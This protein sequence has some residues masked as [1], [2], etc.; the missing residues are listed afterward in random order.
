VALV[1]VNALSRTLASG[2]QEHGGS[3]LI[4]SHN[5][6]AAH[7]L[8][9]QLGCRFILFEALYTT[10]HDVLIVCDHERHLMPGSAASG[11]HPGYLKPGMTVIDLTA[12]L[13][14]TPL[15][16]E[17]QSRNCAIIEPRRLLLHQLALQGRLLTGKEVTRE[18]IEQAMPGLLE[19]EEDWMASWAHLTKET[20]GEL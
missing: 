1:G 17:A 3:P 8:A 13:S 5:K 15:L 9:K 4:V 7:E 12:T 6:A 14:P 20:E 16:R 11:V 2:I 19:N 18:L 10:V